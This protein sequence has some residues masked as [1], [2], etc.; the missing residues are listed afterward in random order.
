MI[1][2]QGVMIEVKT[3]DLDKWQNDSIL[4]KTYTNKKTPYAEK[5]N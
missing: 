5:R 4:G 2:C 3:Y 1:S